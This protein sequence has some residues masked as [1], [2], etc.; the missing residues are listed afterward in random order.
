ME[1]LFSLDLEGRSY[2]IYTLD[3]ES[4]KPLLKRKTGPPGYEWLSSLVPDTVY[5]YM[6]NLRYDASMMDTPITLGGK[7]YKTG[8]AT[9]ADSR[10]VYQLNGNY[11][12]FSAVVGI[13]KSQFDSVGSV[14]FRVRCDGTMVWESRL[15]KADGSAQI[16][17]VPVE[18]VNT[19]ELELNDGGDGNHSDHGTWADGKLMKK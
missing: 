4:W 15:L 8:L 6:G 19:L 2:R 1:P 12:E 5:Q 11:K 3:D 13:D 14:I 9:H 18:G 17:K 7:T 16:F 10:L